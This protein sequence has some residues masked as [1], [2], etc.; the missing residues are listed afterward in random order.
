MIFFLAC[1]NLII[2]FLEK[3][4]PDIEIF[5]FIKDRLMI[6]IPTNRIKTKLIT[7]I[8]SKETAL[9]LRAAISEF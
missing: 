6:F 3:N 7:K 5:L 1:V 4:L 9:W 8:K 2:F